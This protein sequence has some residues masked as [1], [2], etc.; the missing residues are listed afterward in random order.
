MVIRRTVEQMDVYRA[1]ARRRYL[2]EQAAV[3]AREKS[4]WELARQATQLL[5]ERFGVTR[6]MLFGSLVHP[7]AFTLH[8]D[9][10]IAAWGLRPEDTL[11]ALGA[12]ADLSKEIELNLVDVA[13][14]RPA[15]LQAILSEGVTL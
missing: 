9:V 3:K 13:T 14:A 7:G 2:E 5:K 8:S 1:T 15:I 6:I 4:A 10:D 12:V 11:R